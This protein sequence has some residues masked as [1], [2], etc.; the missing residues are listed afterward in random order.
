MYPHQM[1]AAILFVPAAT[2]PPPHATSLIALRTV[3][4]LLGQEAVA[5][6]RAGAAA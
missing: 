4:G 2:L 1:V 5:V 6:K 3:H